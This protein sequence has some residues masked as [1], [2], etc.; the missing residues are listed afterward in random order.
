M[1]RPGVPLTEGQKTQII[2]L[3]TLKGWKVPA[4]IARKVGRKAGTVEWFMLRNG[5]INRAPIRRYTYMRNGV[6]IKPFSEI[7][8]VRLSELR[9]QGLSYSKVAEVLSVE[10]KYK[11]RWHSIRSR[12]ARLAAAP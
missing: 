2:N 12:V 6:E 1:P 3:V 8:D 9:S 7:E 10:F 5:L 4:R 11:R